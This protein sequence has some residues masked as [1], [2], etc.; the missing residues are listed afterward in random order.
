MMSNYSKRI[1]QDEIDRM[2][3][4]ILKYIATNQKELALKKSEFFIN[5]EEETYQ[6]YTDSC[7]APTGIISILNSDG[8][9]IIVSSECI[10]FSNYYDRVIEDKPVGISAGIT[11]SYLE[12]F[13]IFV[14][15]FHEKLQQKY[16]LQEL[17]ELTITPLGFTLESV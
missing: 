9:E 4:A 6:L 11:K 3:N 15:C 16:D 12:L 14:F 1:R 13:C 5:L 17:F 10:N 2:V 7:Q 8:N